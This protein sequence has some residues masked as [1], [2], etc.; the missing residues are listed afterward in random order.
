METESAS[1]TITTT[2]ITAAV[3]Q[4]TT[5]PQSSYKYCSI[6]SSIYFFFY[7]FF[8]R[9]HLSLLFCS[10]RTFAT[11]H[12]HE[13][14]NEAT[15]NLFIFRLIEWLMSG[16]PHF[17]LPLLHRRIAAITS[18]HLPNVIALL[19]RLRPHLSHYSSVNSKHSFRLY[20]LFASSSSSSSLSSSSYTSN[21][22]VLFLT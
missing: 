18:S 16:H 13:N 21:H 11:V 17:A 9:C 4:T 14:H 12:R 5:T 20:C 10:Q 22:S 19:L 7:F 8:F 1:T 6:A 3:I 2:T 15:T